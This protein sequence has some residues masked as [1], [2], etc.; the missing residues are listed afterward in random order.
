M[1]PAVQILRLPPGFLQLHPS[2]L[3]LM[4]SLHPCTAQKLDSCEPPPELTH[5]SVPSPLVPHPPALSV[6]PR[7]NRLLDEPRRRNE[8]TPNPTHWRPPSSS[9]FPRAHVRLDLKYD[10]SWRGNDERFVTGR[11]VEVL[12]NPFPHRRRDMPPEPLRHSP[13]DGSERN[14]DREATLTGSQ[15]ACRPVVF[16]EPQQQPTG[17]WE[18]GSR[19]IFIAPE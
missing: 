19:R 2:H 15:M 1:P 9:P 6:N 11:D 13:P 4:P 17:R 3:P 12:P 14:K 7:Q 10:G 18:G 5:L 8:N 16:C